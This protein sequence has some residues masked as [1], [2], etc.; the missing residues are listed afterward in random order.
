MAIN[1]SYNA[2]SIALSCCRIL[3]AVLC[4]SLGASES[5]ELETLSLN[6][7]DTD[8]PDLGW[9]VQND[10]VMGGKSEGGFNISSGQL[11]FSGNTNTDGGGFSSIRS[12][13]LALNLSA[14]DGIRVKVKADGRRYTWGIQTDARWR[15][16]RVGYWADFETVANEVNVID[17][18]F[19]NFFPQYRGFKLDGPQLNVRQIS[20]F[21]LYQYDKT[22]GPF[23]LRLIS[24]EAYIGSK[25]L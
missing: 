4:S 21:A 20:E 23:E 3:T 13:P 10:N 14:Y 16:R 5:N 18:P 24:V 25:E 6:S 22:D 15:G 8:S 7:F 12:K 9:Y 11:I 2:R 1:Q 17:I 19:A